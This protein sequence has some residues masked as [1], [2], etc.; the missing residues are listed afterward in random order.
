MQNSGDDLINIVPAT[1]KTRKALLPVWMKVFMWIFLVFGA[2]VPIVLMMG[3]MG[4]SISLAL[5]GFETTEPLSIPGLI[6]T[7]CF[8]LK[9]VVAYGFLRGRPWAMNL[10][11]IDAILGIVLCIYMMLQ[12]GSVTTPGRT[13]FAFRLELLL[14]VPYLIKALKLR[15]LWESDVDLHHIPE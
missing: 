12:P 14:L 9:A 6:L 5:Y 13:E 4:Y 11:V 2:L 3:L 7:A 8:S 1:A 15:K 10:A